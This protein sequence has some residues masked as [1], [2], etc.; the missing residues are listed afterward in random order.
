MKEKLPN[1]YKELLQSIKHENIVKILAIVSLFYASL[2]V[3]YDVQE[4]DEFEEDDYIVLELCLT[5]I[6]KVSAYI[7]VPN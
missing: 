2:C 4:T 1:D 6:E 7:V 3:N 5:S